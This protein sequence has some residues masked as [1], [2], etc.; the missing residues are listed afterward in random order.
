MK[1][2]RQLKRQSWPLIELLELLSG[3]AAGLSIPAVLAMVPPLLVPAGV[4]L[5]AL[6]YLPGDLALALF[7]LGWLF[8]AGRES[9]LRFALP[10]G[11]PALGFIALRSLDTVWILA[12]GLVCRLYW[13]WPQS[14]MVWAVAASLTGYLGYYSGVSLLKSV[15]AKIRLA[16]PEAMVAA[17]H[18]FLSR[19]TVWGG[20][21]EI[22]FGF[23]AL[24]LLAGQPVWGLA[25]AVAAG[26]LNWIVRSYNFWRRSRPDDP[27]R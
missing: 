13:G 16:F 24:G 18:F 26:N 23:T 14:V 10:A 3:K 1:V 6:G 21:R 12:V 22:V 15:P 7:L 9:P 17:D 4:C 20:E 5:Y 8:L 25:A 27:Q 2:P 11:K 19:R